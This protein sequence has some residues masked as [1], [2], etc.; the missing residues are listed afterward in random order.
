METLI[1]VPRLGEAQAIAAVLQS[2]VGAHL[3]D[4]ARSGLAE[5]LNDDAVAR[6]FELYR[7]G[8]RGELRGVLRTAHVALADAC[9]S[10]AE[11]ITAALIDAAYAAW[12]PA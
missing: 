4:D 5:V 2:R 6:L 7:T 10:G 1:E 3:P 8:L 12:E 9:D 11:A